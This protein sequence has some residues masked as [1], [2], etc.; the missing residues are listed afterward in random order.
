MPI[1]PNIGLA[2]QGQPAQDGFFIS[3]RFLP[4]P[5]GPEKKPRRGIVA[6]V[7]ALVER[8]ADRQLD[9]PAPGEERIGGE[10]DTAARNSIDALPPRPSS[11]CSGLN[12][13]ILTALQ[14]AKILP[15]EFGPSPAAVLA[16]PRFQL[17]QLDARER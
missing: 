13:P 4:D 11:S 3:I 16:P 10:V 14:L 2:G 12:R 15:P 7:G 8:A 5:C 1:G 9:V 6:F 17:T